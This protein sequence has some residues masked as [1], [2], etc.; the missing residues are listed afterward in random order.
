MKEDVKL[1]IEK[2]D[3]DLKLAKLAFSSQIYDYSAFHAQ[4]AVEKY[5]KAFLIFHK[6]PILKIHDIKNLI[7]S[8]KKIDSSFEELFNIKADKLTL[9]STTSRYPEYEFE[10]SEQEAKEAI[11]I[12]EKV[13]EFVLKN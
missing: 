1:W 7:N 5:L 12:A 10:I 2:A 9:Y 4:Q 13:K 11:E 3:K 6:Q 8:C